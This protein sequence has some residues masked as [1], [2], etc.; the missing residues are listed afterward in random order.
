MN[1]SICEHAILTTIDTNRSTEPS[2]TLEIKE[3]SVTPQELRPLPMIKTDQ[4]RR[5][6]SQKSEILTSTPYKKRS[7][8]EKTLKNKT[9][10]PNEPDAICPGCDEE[11]VDPPDED[12]I[13]CLECEKWWHESC[14]NYLGG[15]YVCDFCIQ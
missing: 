6:I 4:N 8:Q 1:K 14:S 5:R 15:N 3:M 7:K 9:N 12:W 11:F 13:Q 10:A 2:K